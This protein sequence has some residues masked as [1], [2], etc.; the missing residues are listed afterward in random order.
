MCRGTYSFGENLFW[1]SE[2]NRAVEDK[3]GRTGKRYVLEPVA[4][5]A[6]ID[7]EGVA[8]AD[9]DVDRSGNILA[10]RENNCASDDASAAGQ[11]FIFHPALVG[12]NG[13]AARSALL[14]EVGVG[15]A[16]REHRVAPD[17]CS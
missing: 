14:A 5:A 10:Y 1:L 3:I 9:Q 13:D 6:E 7:L 2:I 4:L 12:A 11:G 16:R 15:P 8:A 17:N